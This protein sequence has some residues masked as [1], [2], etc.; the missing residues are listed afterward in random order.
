MH[1]VAFYLPVYLFFHKWNEVYCDAPVLLLITLDLMKK[2]DKLPSN[3]P[4]AHFLLSQDNDKCPCDK[5]VIGE[6]S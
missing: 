1:Y 3:V 2:T 4:L 6:V 5:T